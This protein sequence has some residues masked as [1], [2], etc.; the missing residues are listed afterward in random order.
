[1]LCR[2]WWREQHLTVK[3]CHRAEALAVGDGEHWKHI[4]LMHDTRARFARAA[5][6]GRVIVV[7][8]EGPKST[9]V[10]DEVLDRWLRRPCDLLL[11][12]QLHAIGSG[13]VAALSYCRRTGSA[14][15]CRAACWGT[16]CTRGQD[17]K[18]VS[19]LCVFH[20]CHTT[21]GTPPARTMQWKGNIDSCEWIRSALLLTLSWS[22]PPFHFTS[23][24]HQTTPFF[25]C[26]CYLPTPGDLYCRSETSRSS[27][28]TAPHTLPHSHPSS[29]VAELV[30]GT[31]YSVPEP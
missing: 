1:L 20:T 18:F 16:G 10:F 2:P 28:I 12:A 19:A 22:R 9:K 6:A 21:G 13:V 5:V 4:P 31:Q 29:C 3:S 14:S 17:R 24:L 11:D 25:T 7:E 30:L 27:Y 15:V 8:G 23:H 26:R